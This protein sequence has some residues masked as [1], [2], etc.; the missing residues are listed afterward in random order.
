MNM[1]K[2]RATLGH[3]AMASFTTKGHL[4]HDFQGANLR[5]ESIFGFVVPLK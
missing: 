5:S 1:V 4:Q 3:C 2:I